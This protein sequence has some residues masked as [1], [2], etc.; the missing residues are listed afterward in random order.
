MTE[1]YA[2]IIVDVPTMQTNQP[3]TYAIPASLR[4]TVQVG[5][6]VVV[7]FGGRTV[8]GF[9]VA[10]VPDAPSDVV[11]KPL[12]ELL[13]LAPVLNDEALALS[14]FLAAQT[15]A[16]RISIL[17]T[18][19]PNA[20]KANYEKIIRAVDVEPAIAERLFFNLP[21]RVFVPSEWSE[22]DLALLAKLRRQGKVD[23]QIA[24]HD[25]AKIK[26]QRAY[27]MA[28]DIADATVSKRAVKQQQLL[29][30]VQA[31]AGET[32]TKADLQ[33]M[34]EVSDATL[35]Q[36]VAKQWLIAHDVEKLRRPKTDV[37]VAKVHT[38]NDEQQRALAAISDH[39]GQFQPFLLKG[40]TGSGKTEVYLQA[41]QQVIAAGRSV[42]F[43]VPEIALTPQM[44][45]RVTARFGDQ[46][47]V[48]H[49]GL[50]DGER[51][52]EWRRIE[53]G[54]AKIVVG[55]RS[56]VFA[57]LADIGLIIV[58][59]EHETTYKQSDNP[60]YHARD[61]ALWRGEFHHAPVILGSATPSLE[62]RARA[63]KGVYQLLELTQRAGDAQLPV[64]DVIDLR[65]EMANG[66]ETSF[67][68]A[69]REK[70]QQRL[71]RD[72][73]SV[74]M[75][76]RRGFS[77]FVM[78]RDCGFV[79][80]DPN[81]NLAMT[82]HMDS[83]SLKCHY[84][85]HEEAIPSVCA[86]CG[87]REIRYYG[88]GTEK[89]EA[90]LKE[91]FPEARVLRLDQDTTRKK[92][93]MAT[94]LADFGA[95]KY[96]ILLGTQ[97]IAKGLDFP[98]V[99]LVGVLNADTALGLPDFHAS[100]R[101]F[102]LLTQVAGRAGRATKQGEVVIQTFNPDHYAIQLAQK[103][104]YDDFYLQE[105]Q[106]RKFGQYAPFFYT[107]QIQASHA[108]ENQAAVQLA[109]AAAW[110]RKHL[111]ADLVVLGPSAKPIAKM[112]NRYYYQLIL[113]YKDA[114]TVDKWLAILQ[115]NAQK[116]AK[117]GL[118]LSI[119]REPVNFM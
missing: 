36:A 95:K 114:T 29:A 46:V 63:Q 71:D 32:W 105:M 42:L 117:N 97:M 74:L 34:L 14:E 30:F 72:E 55:A 93:S 109:K 88:T 115:D 111:P 48:L 50:S 61:V 1:L 80:R 52:D 16:F 44:V 99:T 108:D 83:H 10:L 100:E 37:E 59:E 116:A 43:L 64:V 8:L 53:R 6:R 90:E 94:K 27:E 22:D 91:L 101:T 103:Q 119:D 47:A 35:K 18:M 69:L 79:P 17:Q 23:V 60:R 15:F 58:D 102:Q 3:Y 67:S 40:I 9:V 113:K 110:L 73:Q 19:L 81:C 65:H 106:M 28:V 107:V 39:F 51:Y 86:N 77:S 96:D 12:A 104:D 56:A 49:S 84:C 33:A 5:M 85:G 62:S 82:L 57:P 87:S 11:V 76:N 78:C 21:E 66:P 92:G 98:D 31:H 89:V 20:L 41:A 54:D 38:L 2:Q 24:V 4:E 13:D 7:P 25:K 68:A 70:I 112:R 45:N 118:Q 26:T 75:L